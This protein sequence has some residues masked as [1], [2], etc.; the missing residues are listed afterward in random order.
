M[1]TP[2]AQLTLIKGNKSWSSTAVAAALELVVLL[3]LGCHSKFS[4]LFMEEVIERFP[5][6]IGYVV[7][8]ICSFNKNCEDGYDHDGWES[9]PAFDA[10]V[11][12]PHKFSFSFSLPRVWIRPLRR[13]LLEV[14]KVPSIQR[15][16]PFLEQRPIEPKIFFFHSMLGMCCNVSDETSQPN[17]TIV[18]F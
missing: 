6:R 15:R 18:G 14:A 9:A 8:D 12:N 4:I 3:A 11:W 1:I 5:V 17:E 16:P 13:S 10:F 2:S 7:E